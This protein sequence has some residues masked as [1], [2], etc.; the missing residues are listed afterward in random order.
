MDGAVEM[1]E[2]VSPVGALLAEFRWCVCEKRQAAAGTGVGRDHAG[3]GPVTVRQDVI[4]VCI[5]KPV[6]CVAHT[7]R[8]MEEE[9]VSLPVCRLRIFGRCTII[10]MEDRKSTRL[11]SS[12]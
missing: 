2:D 11:N 9:V 12:H 3:F 4:I 1:I 7:R 10:A 8:R 6:E 5:R